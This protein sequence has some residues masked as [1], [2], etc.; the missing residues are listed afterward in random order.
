MNWQH[1]QIEIVVSRINSV[2]M[3]FYLSCSPTYNFAEIQFNNF[4]AYSQLFEAE[5]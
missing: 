3:K 1:K 2:E 5:G 4:R